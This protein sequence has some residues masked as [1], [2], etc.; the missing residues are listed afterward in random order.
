VRRRL[1]AAALGLCSAVACGPDLAAIPEPELSCARDMRYETKR[2]C[3]PLD[4]PAAPSPSI[5]A[6]RVAEAERHRAEGERLYGEQEYDA[7]LKELRAAEAAQPTP[8]GQRYVAL[9]LDA[10]GEVGPAIAA[11]RKFIQGAPRTMETEV[12]EAKARL[13]A[14][15]GHEPHEPSR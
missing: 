5:A 12:V 2:G 13:E 14:L 7:A 1:A 6:A 10:L 4:M 15:A 8:R 9:C 11:Y 3:V